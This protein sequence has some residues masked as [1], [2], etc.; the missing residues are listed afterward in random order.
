MSHLIEWIEADIV[1]IPSLELAF[2]GI[3]YVHHCAAMISF[4]PKMKLYCVKQTL[5]E[6][7]ILLI[8][9][10]QRLKTMLH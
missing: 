7:Q 8:L 10:R 3:E 5:K 9:S 4:D 6:L 2:Q 1:N